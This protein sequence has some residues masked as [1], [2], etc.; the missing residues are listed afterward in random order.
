VAVISE[1]WELRM[2]TP[3]KGQFTSLPLNAEG[4]RVGNAWDPAKDEAAGEQC[5]YYGAASIM[6]IPG[7]L[8]ITWENDTTLRVDT[9]AGTQTRLFH[10]GPAAPGAAGEPSWQGYSSAQWE[11]GPGGGRG[12]ASS[13]GGLKVVTNNLR[14]GYFR[15]NGAPYGKDAIVTEYF[16][17]NTLPNGDKWFT[18]TTKVEDPQYLS[19]YYLTTSDFK[20][21]PDATGWNPTPCSAK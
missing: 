1:D 19:R 16:D 11:T 18:V 17:L 15:R 4:R 10:F 12:G 20:K 14:P 8:H 6:R 13:G 21:V 3:P 7:R 2:I 5:K 9:D